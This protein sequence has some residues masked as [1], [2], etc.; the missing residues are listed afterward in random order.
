[1]WSSIALWLAALLVML[2]A[3]SHQ[4]RTGPTYPW[5]GEVE[6]GGAAVQ[7]EWPRSGV[8]DAPAEVHW[9]AAVD[10]RDLTLQWRRY[11]SDDAYTA[12][13]FELREGTWIASLPVQPAA[14]KLEYTVAVETAAGETMVLPTDE[15]LV[16]RY[17]DPVPIAALLPHVLLMFLSMWFGVRT[18]LAALFGRGETRWLVPVTAIGLTIG[19]MILGPIVQKHAFGAYWTGWPL[20][21]DLTD[22]KTL[23]MWGVWA[24]LAIAFALRPRW[25]PTIGGRLA[26]GVAT[27][28]MLAVYLV[29]HSLRG[30]QLDY[31]ALDA[32]VEAHE[33]IR[34]GKQD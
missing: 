4:R 27:A 22:N 9:P 24:V 14:G 2:S 3:A 12:Q 10:V 28:V 13:D 21:G 31:E 30:S 29:P 20:G 16:L 33:A 6:I 25:R 23:V 5:R 1:M 19:G 17:K 8:T 11:P 18:A 15:P 26:I 32:G 34:T 7:F